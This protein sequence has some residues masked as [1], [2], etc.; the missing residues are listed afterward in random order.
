MLDFGPGIDAAAVEKSRHR[1][2]HPALARVAKLPL[3]VVLRIGDAVAGLDH[4]LGP[5]RDLLG[6]PSASARATNT[7]TPLRAA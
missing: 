3:A 1:G 4:E 6:G 5:G 2:P 7:G